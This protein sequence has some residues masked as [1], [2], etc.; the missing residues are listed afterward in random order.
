MESWGRLSPLGPFSPLGRLV[1]GVADSFAP[2]PISLMLFQVSNE[3]VDDF[4]YFYAM[5]VSALKF[6][7]DD[8]I[9]V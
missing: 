9:L 4:A 3:A 1:F 5:I 8:I 7:S 2:G 6:V